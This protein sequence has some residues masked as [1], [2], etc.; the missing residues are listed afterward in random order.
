MKGYKYGPQY[1]PFGGMDD[2]ILKLKSPP[3]LRLLGFVPAD[4]IPRHHFLDACH[5]V[6]TTHTTT[7]GAAARKVILSLAHAMKSLNQVAL[8]RLVKRENSDPWLVA[9]IPPPAIDSEEGRNNGILYMHRLPCVEDLRNFLF[10]PLTC[11]GKP[12]EA[13]SAVAAAIDSMTVSGLQ[14][15]GLLMYNPAHLSVLSALQQKAGASKTALP[16]VLNF[17][18][19]FQSLGDTPECHTAWVKVRKH[20]D[21]QFRDPDAEKGRKKKKIYW[22]DVDITGTG[23]VVDATS[24]GSGTAEGE[25][26]VKEEVYVKSEE[27]KVMHSVHVAA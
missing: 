12:L 17:D 2:D 22:A 14:S 8:A 20:F 27:T 24:S 13:T 1:I 11:E 23:G 9:L 25:V 15:D 10:P 18:D 26:S 6:G 16:G 4:S 5:V 3:V 21:L 7:D 19:T